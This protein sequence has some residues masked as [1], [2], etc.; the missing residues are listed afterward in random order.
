MQLSL[1]FFQVSSSNHQKFIFTQ[2]KNILNLKYSCSLQF[3]HPRSFRNSETCT[4]ARAWIKD[5]TCQ[6]FIRLSLEKRIELTGR[7][8]GRSIVRLERREGFRGKRPEFSSTNHARLHGA[9][10]SVNNAL[11]STLY[12]ENLSAK[13]RA[14]GTNLPRQVTSFSLGS[15]K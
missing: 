9:V 2:T 15:P 4:L 8:R 6:F 10:Q 13:R 3:S 1:L 5:K 14:S 7:E 12:G 11:I